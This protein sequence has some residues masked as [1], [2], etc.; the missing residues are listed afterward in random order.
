VCIFKKKSQQKQMPEN[1]ETEDSVRVR[2][3]IKPNSK[4][5]LFHARKDLLPQFMKGDLRLMVDWAENDCDSILYW[6]RPQ[7]D[8]R[9][10]MIHL[11]RQIKTR[12][13][14]W[15]I[16]KAN[17]DANSLSDEISEYTNLKK[18]KIVDIGEGESALQFT[19]RKDTGE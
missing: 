19:I 16:V 10:I 17:E 6:L 2:L 11:E 4:V 12:G 14:I 1:S 3:S 9:D 13:R 18:G 8:L 5:C 7:D 15:L